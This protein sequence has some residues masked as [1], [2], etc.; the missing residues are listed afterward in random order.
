MV[1]PESEEI[2]EE[3]LSKLAEDEIKINVIDNYKI[4]QTCTRCRND[5][6]VKE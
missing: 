1:L 2:I 3:A 4:K 6:K 5:F